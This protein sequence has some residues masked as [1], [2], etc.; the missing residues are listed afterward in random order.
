[1]LYILLLM[2]REVQN[3]DAIKS[4]F[5]IVDFGLTSPD[6]EED[7]DIPLTPLQ[8]M[9]IPMKQID[10]THISIEDQILIHNNFN[11]DGH[12]NENLDAYHPTDADNE[13]TDDDSQKA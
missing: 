5:L 10:M 4:C 2:H 13:G 9:S 8:C 12:M 1:M 3:P 11:I 6:S 7:D